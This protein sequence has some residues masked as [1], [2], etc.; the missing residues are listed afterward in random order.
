ME[1]IDQITQFVQTNTLGIVGVSILLA[2]VLGV[3]MSLAKKSVFYA[4]FNDL[5]VSMGMCA[6]PA[7]VLMVGLS[8]GQGDAPRYIAGAIFV[9]LFLKSVVRTYKTN[10][11]SIWKTAVL[12]VGKVTLSFL[13]IVY[14]LEALTAKKRSDRGKAWF[15]LAILT[16]LMLALTENHKGLFRIMPMGRMR[17][18]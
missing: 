14:L 9:G 13:Y 6:L 18:L 3:A 15:V 5:A 16:P 1:T 11:G 17:H 12:M 2:T 10:N 7:L 8:F 4:D